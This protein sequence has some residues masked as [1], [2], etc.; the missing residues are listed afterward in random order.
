MFSLVVRCDRCGRQTFVRYADV[1]PDDV[2][3]QRARVLTLDV[4]L[5]DRILVVPVERD[6]DAVADG[7][8]EP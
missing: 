5:L 3:R 8:T 1:K 7:R 4:D 6:Y 2:E